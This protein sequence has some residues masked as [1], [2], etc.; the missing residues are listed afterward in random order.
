MAQIANV[1]IVPSAISILS[2]A[3]YPGTPILPVFVLL[4]LLF[5]VSYLTGLVQQLVGEE[6]NTLHAVRSAVHA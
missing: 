1:K 3:G 5:C 6:P 4:F 2:E